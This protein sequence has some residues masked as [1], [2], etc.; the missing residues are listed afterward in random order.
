M[1]DLHVASTP[2]MTNILPKL[3]SRILAIASRARRP[4]PTLEEGQ[5]R[6]GAALQITCLVL[7]RKMDAAT[8]SV[9]S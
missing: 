7:T 3:M 5:T 9:V 4:L 6:R 2:R 1:M 8:A